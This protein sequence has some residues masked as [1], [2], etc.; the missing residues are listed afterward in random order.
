ML[1]ILQKN[2]YICTAYNK[3]ML[4]KTLNNAPDNVNLPSLVCY[5]P[6]LKGFIFDTME[7]RRCIKCGKIK[8]IN[9]FRECD[10]CKDGFRLKC[11]SCN[12]DLN[13]LYKRTKHGLLGRIYNNQRATSRR[14][15]HPLPT[16]TKQE[17]LDFCLNLPDF[18]L[19]YDEWVKSDY[20]KMLIPSFDRKDDYSGYSF[21]N[22]NKF[23]TWQKNF[24]RGHSD[25]KNGINNKN[26]RAVVG[27]NIKTNQVIEFYS[28]SE[29]KR[30]TGINHISSACSGKKIKN[31]N[32][33]S[34][35]IKSAG[36]YKWNYK[37]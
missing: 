27:V 11:K 17:F 6:R 3:P 30:K 15:N 26:S 25:R 28:I 16:Y 22:F 32:G 9:E 23:G 7:T 18:H 19:L 12:G 34:C 8:D 14:R 31:G 24:N 37:K 10:T 1:C 21:E 20:Q 2:N 33:N 5:K 13:R 29:A 4:Q 35:I 36:G